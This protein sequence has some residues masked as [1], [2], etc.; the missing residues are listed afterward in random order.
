MSYQITE[1]NH[2]IRRVPE[3]P[4]HVEQDGVGNFVRDADGRLQP[5]STVFKYSPDGVSV[6]VLEIWLALGS[7][8][9]ALARAAFNHLTKSGAHHLAAILPATVPL[10]LSL[11]C[12]HDPVSETEGTPANPA[13][14]LI[15]GEITKTIA[16]KL[17]KACQFV[18][19]PPAL[20][21]QSSID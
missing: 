16:R 19:R 18:E 15:Q 12:V 10:S 7:Y 6:D 17:A 5:T 4:S 20:E 13:H 11:A 2:L 14:A 3:L 8:E 21:I 9:D 1:A